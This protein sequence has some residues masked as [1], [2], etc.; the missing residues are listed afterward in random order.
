MQ[1]VSGF[2]GWYIAL[3]LFSY[4]C[5]TG[6]LSSTNEPSE[7]TFPQAGPFSSYSPMNISLQ[8]QAALYERGSMQLH[9]GSGGSDFGKG[10]SGYL[11]TE[12][13]YSRDYQRGLSQGGYDRRPGQGQPKSK[14]CS[15]GEA[16]GTRMVRY[17]DGGRVSVHGC[18]GQEQDARDLEMS[19]DYSKSISGLSTLLTDSDDSDMDV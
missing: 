5:S 1:V 3:K 6:S 13:R 16:H 7:G 8:A 19:L 12:C 17:A 15:L 4:T 2:R 14:Y 10:R 9:Q 11:A 18:F